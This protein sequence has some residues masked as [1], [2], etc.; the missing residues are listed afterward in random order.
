LS[1]FLR[2]WVIS[3][4][5]LTGGFVKEVSSAGEKAVSQTA[6]P[7]GRIRT[8]SQVWAGLCFGVPAV[9][10]AIAYLWLAWDHGTLLLW[11][12]VVHEGG[13]HTF[14][15]TVLYFPHFLR[16][17]PTAI[18]LSL[19]VLAAYGPSRA[20][21]RA[22]SG[23]IAKV[24]GG[25]FLSASFAMVA[26]ALVMAAAQHGAA[27]ALRDL[28]QFRTRDDLIEYGSHWRFHWLSTLWFGIATVVVARWGSALGS[29]APRSRRYKRGLRRAAWLY[30]VGLTLIFGLSGDVLFDA[31]YIGHQAREILTL[32][33]VTLPMLLGAIAVTSRY[34]RGPARP[35]VRVGA[36]GVLEIA[37]LLLIPVYLARA[38]LFDDVMSA[39][40]TDHGLAAMVAAHFFEHVLDYAFVTLLVCGLALVLGGARHDTHLRHAPAGQRRDGHGREAIGERGAASGADLHGHTKVLRRQVDDPAG[41][42]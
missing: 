37:A 1:E 21:R 33:L 13:R 11:R 39:G 14:A 4:H 31:R 29:P 24:R 35:R 22:P 7:V 42:G 17:I 23:R 15:Q 41:P 25:L 6:A 3:H 36:L 19:F 26:V 30:F 34:H 5:V 32:A 27:E 38:V 9:I 18:A 8:R 2:H 20:S 40:Q 12:V 28:L 16:E 10:L